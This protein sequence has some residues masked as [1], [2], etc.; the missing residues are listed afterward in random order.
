MKKFSILA[1]AAAGL[2]VAACSTKDMV[3]EGYQDV[4]KGKGQGFIN[5]AI[6][7]P[8]QEGPSTRAWGEADGQGNTDKLDDGEGYEYNVNEV[9][10]IIFGGESEATA[11]VQQVVSPTAGTWTGIEEDNPN[12]VTQR[13]NYVV[14]LDEKATGPFWILAVLNGNGVIGMADSKNISINGVKKANAKLSD[15]QD[16]GVLAEFQSEGVTKFANAT[17]SDNFFMTNAVLSKTVSGTEGISYRKDATI[18]A[19]VTKVFVSQSEAEA[20]SATPSADI[21]VERGLVKVTVEKT[22]AFKFD[23]TITTSGGVAPTATPTFKWVLDNTNRRSFIVRKVNEGDWGLKSQSP[24]A[25]RDVYRFVGYTNVDA[26][27]EPITTA[28]RTYWSP[29]PNYSGTSGDYNK[30]NFYEPKNK[31]FPANTGAPQYCYEN[32]FDVDHQTYEN[33]TRVVVA[34]DLNGEGTEHFYTLGADRKTLYSEDDIKKAVY[35]RILQE[36]DFQTWILANIKAGTTVNENIFK[37]LDWSYAA[38]KAGGIHATDVTIKKDALTSDTDTKLSSITNGNAILRNANAKAGKIN[39]YVNGIAYYAIRIKHFGDDLTPWNTNEYGNGTQPAESGINDIYP[40]GTN[41]D[42]NYLGRYGVLRNNWYLLSLGTI[43][44]IGHPIVPWL[45]PE[46]KPDDPRDPE[47]PDPTDPTD[48]DDPVDPNPEDPDH[49]D[50]SL[51]DTYLNAR[52]NI[53]SWALRP[54]SWSLK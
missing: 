40:P 44:K 29:D 17:T 51:E 16:I 19:P 37:S 14:K 26:V 12:Q 35:A 4:T 28:Y 20:G 10:L 43:L 34:V 9:L 15:L 31:T 23:N 22:A 50:D 42:A 3:E 32:T 38:D 1:L 53:L 18:L 5:V 8:T 24:T 25:A 7:L 39:R 6:S 36:Q 11:T 2:L 30:S 47:N 45:N 48:P 54:Q 41:R 33:T 46:N 27:A 21:Y 49:P 13:K 52:I